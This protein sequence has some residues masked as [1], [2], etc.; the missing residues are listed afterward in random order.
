[1]ADTVAGPT[2]KITAPEAGVAA[3]AA[4]AAP[5]EET[6]EPAGSSEPF[7][8]AETRIAQIGSFLLL[9][10][11]SLYFSKDFAMP[12]ALA[13]LFALVLSPVVRRL[14]KL[15][16]PE[17]VSA[18]A[19]V[20]I[21]ILTTAAVVVLLAS[22]VQQWVDDAPRI[23]RELSGKMS[24]LREPI[25]QVVEA[26]KRIEE[27]AT[28]ST[29]SF[30]RVVV[31]EPGLLSQA[32]TGIPEIAAKTA[33]CV[34]LLYFL[35]ASGDL[36]YEKLVRVL[37]TFSDK[38]RGVRIARGIEREVSR[39]LFTITAINMVLGLVLSAAMWA[40]GLPNP[41]VWGM[42]GGVLN[43]LPFVGAVVSA[44]IVFLVAFVTFDTL[45]MMLFAPGLFYLINLVEGQFITPSLVGRR[46]EMNPVAVF[47]SVAFWGWLWGIAG[48]IMAVPFL[49]IVKILS[50]H[51]DG[52]H[53]IG[54][55]LS[56]RSSEI[57][58]DG[59]DQT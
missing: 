25:D 3:E 24:L 9:V 31:Q 38:K 49:V 27:S 36:F 8:A 2:K 45:E 30:Q 28:D 39:Y 13:F 29:P 32:A 10:T 41:F 17:G 55:F 4:A 43:Y 21:V 19:L 6:G 26:S 33:L 35:L 5:G 23:M 37:P 14:R 53:G 54:E 15:G 58:D 11:A 59:G 20:V 47:A 40:V 52:Y 16:I 12:V 7:L 34:L 18:A 51:I 1:M 22:P 56:A 42:I 46:L 50:D 44:G 48:A 57:A